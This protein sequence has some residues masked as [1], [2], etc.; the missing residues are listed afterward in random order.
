M[1]IG[2]GGSAKFVVGIGGYSGLIIET[3]ALSQSDYMQGIGTYRTIEGNVGNIGAQGSLQLSVSESKYGVESGEGMSLSGGGSFEWGLDVDVLYDTDEEGH[4]GMTLNLGLGASTLPV[5]GHAGVSYTDVTPLG[6]TEIGRTIGIIQQSIQAYF[7]AKEF[8]ANQEHLKEQ[9]RIRREQEAKARAK[10]RRRRRNTNKSY[11][12]A[13]GGGDA[14][15][16][17]EKLYSAW[18]NVKDV[19]D[20]IGGK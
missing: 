10:A 16:G 6:E 18:D 9:E 1:K 11:L 8:L 12:E 2:G 3:E 4:S 19:Y 5:S 13:V 7:T 14:E 20:Q 15:A 17:F